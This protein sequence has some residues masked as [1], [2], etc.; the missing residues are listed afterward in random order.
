MCPSHTIPLFVVVIGPFG[1]AVV[2]ASLVCMFPRNSDVFWRVMH[3]P[4]VAGCGVNCSAWTRQTMSPQ[5]CGIATDY[6][7]G[8]AGASH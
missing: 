7:C 2:I 4:P 8:E 5:D 1:L 6:D 3:G